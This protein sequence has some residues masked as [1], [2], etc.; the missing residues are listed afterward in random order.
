M[1]GS[2]DDRGSPLAGET[3]Y[4]P[5]I[6]APLVEKV[7]RGHTEVLPRISTIDRLENISPIDPAS[8][9]TPVEEGGH[10]R[11]QPRLRGREQDPSTLDM[12]AVR[13]GTS[14]GRHLHVWATLIETA[15]RLR[16]GAVPG[17]AAVF[18]DQISAEIRGIQADLQR[19]GVAR[20]VVART[21]RAVVA[22]LDEAALAGSSPVRAIWHARPLQMEFRGDLQIGHAFFADL[23]EVERAL[24][25]DPAEAEIYLLCLLTGFTGEEHARPQVLREHMDALRGAITRASPRTTL[26]PDKGRPPPPPPMS[27]WPPPIWATALVTSLMLGVLLL[28]MGFFVHRRGEQF[29]QTVDVAAPAVAVGAGG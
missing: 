23:R 12:K 18:R 11:Q 16:T 25:E 26:S 14:G 27:R 13:T 5:V 9:V 20:Q 8:V 15:S 7:Q 3:E 2:R 24:D 21:T 4:M 19:A 6:R 17:D 1:T 22:T 10:T 28:A 29:V